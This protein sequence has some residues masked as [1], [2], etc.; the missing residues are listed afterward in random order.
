[1]HS[2]NKIEQHLIQQK[3]RAVQTHLNVADRCQYRTA[4][5]LM[6]AAGCLIP[7]DKY[8]PSMEG[9]T[10]DAVKRNHDDVFPDDI[11]SRELTLWQNYH[12]YVAIV[13][14]FTYSYEKWIDGDED[15]HPSKFKVAVI[16][17]TPPYYQVVE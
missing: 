12:D 9:F 8:R 15:H 2:R 6:C 14:G 4:E 11:A 17:A 13:G 16:A 7:D 10:T 1:M 5:G 3:A